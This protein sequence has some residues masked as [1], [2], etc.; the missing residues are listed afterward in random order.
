MPVALAR[1]GKSV[2]E[3]HAYSFSKFVS[4]DAPRLVR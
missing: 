1:P 3:G 2:G 4:T